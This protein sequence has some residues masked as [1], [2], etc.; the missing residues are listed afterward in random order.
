MSNKINNDVSRLFAAKC[1]GNKFNKLTLV[2]ILG[3][4]KHGTVVR[5]LC[6]CGNTTDVLFQ[7]I[8]HGRVMSCGCIKRINN[9]S[10]NKTINLVYPGSKFGHL[11]VLSY[12]KHDKYGG[13][14]VKCKCDCGTINIV[15]AY[16]LI[17]QT[18]PIVSCGCIPPQ[19]RESLD[20]WKAEYNRYKIQCAD[21]R[22][23]S[24]EISQSDFEDLVKS[25]CIY[26]GTEKS[27]KLRSGNKMRNGIDRIDNTIGYLKSN[28]APCC[29]MCNKIKLN[30]SIEEFKIQIKKIY[31]HFVHS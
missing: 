2:E 9:S 14:M 24:W 18:R 21:K 31:N 29:S 7:T 10:K 23:L 28:C 30:Y 11:T 6:D 13:Q 19:W 20:P 16:S 17:K 26:C 5:C 22:K 4:N 27:V 8:S 25:P 1:I 12:D 3:K 15:K